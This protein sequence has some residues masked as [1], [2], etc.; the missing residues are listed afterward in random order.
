MVP[1]PRSLPLGSVRLES[2]PDHLALISSLQSL[3]DG[4]I[5]PDGALD[6]RKHP[7]SEVAPALRAQRVRCETLVQGVLERAAAHPNRPL[8]GFVTERVTATNDRDGRIELE[9]CLASASGRL[10][11]FVVDRGAVSRPVL[12]SQRFALT[13]AAD[14]PLVSEA[15]CRA[16]RSVLLAA[17]GTLP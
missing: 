5:F 17:E 4:R 14:T 15:R 2:R 3:L 10:R 11:L 12:R 9:V 1:P 7:T 16:A 8:A 13:V 6:G